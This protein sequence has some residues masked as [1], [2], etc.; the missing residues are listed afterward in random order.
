MRK[1]QGYVVKGQDVFIG[2]E[3]S[4]RTWKLCVRS[5]NIIIHETSMP[6]EYENLRNYL[7]NGYPECRISVIYEAG[8]RGFSLHDKLDVDGYKCFV[9]PPH[10]VTEEK[11]RRQ[12]NDRID[13]RR[14]AKNL[15]NNDFGICFVP[16]KQR[17]EDR[18]I[19]R[20]YGQLQR[21]CTR[22]SNRIRRTL[23]FHDLDWQFKPG[24]WSRCDYKASR[25]Q[26]EKMDLPESLRLSLRLLYDELEYLW[27]LQKETLSA[28]RKL[29]K[30]PAYKESVDLVKSV[31]GIGVLTAVR[32]VLEW[33]DVSRFRRKEEFASFLG[34]IP[35]EYS[36]GEMEHK[37]HITKQGNRAIR[38]WLIESSWVAI[39][40]DPV[41]LDKFMRVYRSSGSKKKAIVA[42][43]RKLALRIRAVLLKKELYM[44][45]IAA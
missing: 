22:V 5:A 41:L 2:L 40:R 28:I 3:D 21:D 16:S 9:T 37:G 24:R 43:A 7:R 11:C 13:S 14:L 36:S 31:P 1:I 32:L 30:S 12:K 6:A 15:E 20:L 8:F 27:A 45:G 25:G 35:S 26:W 38:S 4:K 17:R 42:V 18:Q 33:G 19:V 39:R 29:S 23:E 10:T 34:L 44:I